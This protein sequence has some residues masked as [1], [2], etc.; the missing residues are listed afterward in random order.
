MSQGGGNGF[1]LK[2][3]DHSMKSSLNWMP[4]SHSESPRLGSLPTAMNPPWPSMLMSSTLARDSSSV[5]RSR[6]IG[7]PR[8]QV[9]EKCGPRMP[10]PA[11]HWHPIE[12]LAVLTRPVTRVCSAPVWS[13][14]PA[15]C[16]KN[17]PCLT[18]CG[19]CG[20]EGPPPGEAELDPDEHAAN[21]G[22]MA[23]AATASRFALPGITAH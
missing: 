20:L 15:H 21:S 8:Y 4:T 13:L 18:P 7:L 1:W 9:N 3:T 5:L 23:A 2:L 16:G 11:S 19:A 12:F 22:I 14:M 10:P 6:P 17:G